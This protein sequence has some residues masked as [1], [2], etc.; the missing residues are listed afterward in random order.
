M[1]LY[2]RSDHLVFGI[3]YNNSESSRFSLK[4]SIKNTYNYPVSVN[5]MVSLA[6]K[7]VTLKF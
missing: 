3:E 6:N 5:D 4:L 7:E 1:I 2:T